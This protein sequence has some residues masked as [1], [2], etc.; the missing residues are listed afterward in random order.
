MCR[1]FHQ[2]R[3]MDDLFP[4]NHGFNHGLNILFHGFSHTF[5][6]FDGENGKTPWFPVGFQVP[7]SNRYPVTPLTSQS[8]IPTIACDQ[9]EIPTSTW[10]GFKGQRLISCGKTHGK[11]NPVPSIYFSYFQFIYLID[12]YDDPITIMYTNN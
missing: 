8:S 9:R 7:R 2:P 12:V 4:T 3:M 6:I 1:A 5:S 10:H 11:K